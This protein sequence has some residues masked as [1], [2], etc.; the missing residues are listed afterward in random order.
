VVDSSACK[1]QAGAD[2]GKQ[3]DRQASGM[4]W[5]LEDEE[6]ASTGISSSSSGTKLEPEN[7]SAGHRHLRGASWRRALQEIVGGKD[8]RQVCPNRWPFTAVGQLDVAGSAPDESAMA[9]SGVLIGP[10][11]V[12][13]AAHCVWDAW[14]STFYSSLGFAAGRRNTS[15]CEVLSPWGV[16]PWRHVTVLK[17]YADSLAPDV[18]VI[19]LASPVGLRTGWVGLKASCRQLAAS[20][21]GQGQSRRRLLGAAS[22]VS[23]VLHSSV[24]LAGYPAGAA[25]SGSATVSNVVFAPGTCAVASCRVQMACDAV[26]SGD[27]AASSP[28]SPIGLHHECDATPGQSGSPMID[29]QSYVRLVHSAG[30][31][32]F[33]GSGAEA[34]SDNA[35]TLITKFIFD[36]IVLW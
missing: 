19:R 18:A 2:S 21:A 32:A 5:W 29:E 16:V 7:V 4:P 35:A 27:V 28:S 20:H 22:G 1:R 13:T 31:V 9:C 30:I 3:S 6:D 24:R 25:G 23:S 36:N 8:D 15:T 26:S 33:G 17:T 14:Q 12:L 10:D 34:G 11:K